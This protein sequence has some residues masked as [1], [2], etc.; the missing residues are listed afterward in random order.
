MYLLFVYFVGPKILYE[1]EH[2]AEQ[3]LVKNVSVKVRCKSLTVATLGTLRIS[4]CLLVISRCLFMIEQ[5]PIWESIDFN[6]SYFTFACLTQELLYI[7]QTHFL[8]S[9]YCFSASR[10]KY[11]TNTSFRTFSMWPKKKMFVQCRTWSIQY[12]F[13]W[14]CSNS[15]YFLTH[16]EHYK[17]NLCVWGGTISY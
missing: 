10:L 16:L 13:Y 17:H 5:L 12:Y 2:N 11:K 15:Q 14:C 9:V 4:S 1:Q 8:W 6:V 7:L 3:L